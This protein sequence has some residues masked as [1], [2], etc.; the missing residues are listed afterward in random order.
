MGYD[1]AGASPYFLIKNSWGESWGEKG[2]IRLAMSPEAKRQSSV[3]M[4]G[5]TLFAAYPVG[6]GKP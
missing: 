5:L 1:T 4:C 2:F 3:G 6:G